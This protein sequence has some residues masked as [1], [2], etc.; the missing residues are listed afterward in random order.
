MA[1]S[2]QEYSGVVIDLTSGNSTPVSSM[3]SSSRKRDHSFID[4]TSDDHSAEADRRKHPRVAD[5]PT[6]T[7]P[8]SSRHAPLQLSSDIESEDDDDWGEIVEGPGGS[9]DYDEGTLE[10]LDL[11][12][13]SIP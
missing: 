10:T 4:L 9:Q 12:G 6:N 3:E 5:I 13:Q 1:G 8:G 2:S 11:Y 7:T